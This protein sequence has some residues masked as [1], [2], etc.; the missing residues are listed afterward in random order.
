VGLWG[1]VLSERSGGRVELTREAEA[2]MKGGFL[3]R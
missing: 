2:N 3:V 1:L